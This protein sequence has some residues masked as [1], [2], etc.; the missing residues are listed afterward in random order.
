MIVLAVSDMVASGRR[1]MHVKALRVASRTRLMRLNGAIRLTVPAAAPFLDTDGQAYTNHLRAAMQKIRSRKNAPGETTARGTTAL[2]FGEWA[3][4]R[5]QRL[6]Q[7]GR[8]LS[9]KESTLRCWSGPLARP[10]WKRPFLHWAILPPPC[11][12]AQV[13]ARWSP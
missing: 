13:A 10:A 7:Q 11:F 8:P 9:R 1:T 6:L 4:S 2:F 5:Y 3:H 12:G